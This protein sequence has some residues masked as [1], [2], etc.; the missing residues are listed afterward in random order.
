MTA[1]ERLM[2]YRRGR[3]SE[4]EQEARETYAELPAVVPDAI[5]E[6]NHAKAAADREYWRRLYTMGLQRACRGRKP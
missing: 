1:T 2:T 6:L 3:L 4:A 5:A